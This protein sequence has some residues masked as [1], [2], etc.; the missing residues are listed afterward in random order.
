MANDRIVDTSRLYIL[1]AVLVLSGCYSLLAAK[2]MTDGARKAEHAPIQ[3]L[4]NA[5]TKP[6]SFD[7]YPV[8]Y[9]SA[10]NQNALRDPNSNLWRY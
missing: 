7:Y 5:G 2:M 6:L 8:L 4:P 1:L 3:V 9:F 10:P